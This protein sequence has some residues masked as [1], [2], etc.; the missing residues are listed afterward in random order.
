MRTVTTSVLFLGLGIWAS[1]AQAQNIEPGLWEMS[2][3]LQMP[4]KPNMAQMMKQAQ[5]QMKN[6]PP[7]ARKMMEQQ[8][9]ISLSPSGAM[10]IC[11]SAQDVKENLITEGKREND[12]TYTKVSQSGNTWKGHIACVNPP[13][14]GDFSTT[15]HSKSHYTT[16][17]VMTGKEF[18]RVDMKIEA[19]R[20]SADCGNLAPIG[21]G[22]KR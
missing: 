19:R 11:I 18:G 7:E 6:L 17:A 13:S 10:R 3:D 2:H 16:T 21:S 4:G 15:L 1:A 14:Q 20:V 22:K 12:C 5:E 9:G 8:A